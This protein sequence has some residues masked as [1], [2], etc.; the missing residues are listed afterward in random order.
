VEREG[1]RDRGFRYYLITAPAELVD[2]RPYLA[3]VDGK[4]S[5]QIPTDVSLSTKE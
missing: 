4:Y 1:S 3:D 5:S 2:R